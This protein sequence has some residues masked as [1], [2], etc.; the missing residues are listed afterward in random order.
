MPRA[1]LGGVFVLVCGMI[2]MSGIRLIGAGIATG[3]RRTDRTDA[4]VVAPP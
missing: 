3:T 4:L 2:A 1:V